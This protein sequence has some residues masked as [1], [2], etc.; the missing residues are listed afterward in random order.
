MFQHANHLLPGIDR[1]TRRTFNKGRPLISLLSSASPT[2]P[3]AEMLP[4]SLISPSNHWG[5]I[6]VLSFAASLAQL[7]GK[8]TLIGRLLG[9]P[10]TAMA[11]TFVLS[12]L[13]IVPSCLPD[14]SDWLTLLPS[15]GSTASAFL[16]ST[17]LTLAT[18][19]LLLGTSIRGKAL[20]RCGSLLG[21]FVVASMGTLLGAIIAILVTSSSYFLKNSSHGILGPLALPNGDGIKIASAL[22][23]KNIGGG[24]NYMAVCSC[25]NAAP[26]SIAAGLCVDNVMALAYFPLTSVLASKWDDVDDGDSK[27]ENESAHFS[28]VVI[29]DDEASTNIT[30][31]SLSHV[32]TIAAVLTAMGQLL[33]SNLHHIQHFLRIADTSSSINSLNLSLPITTLLAVLFSTYYPPDWFMSPTST[34]PSMTSK[35][36][37]QRNN[38]GRSNSIALAGE[39]LGT[40]LLYLF[41]ATAGAPGWRLKDS[42]QHSFPSIASF[43]II[44]YGVHLGVLW[45]FHRIVSSRNKRNGASSLTSFWDKI[46][47]PQRLLT[48]SSAAIGGPA[49]AAALAQSSQW[50]SLITPSLLVGNIGY[51]V[52]TFIA[53]LFY[54]GFR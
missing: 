23:A 33:N 46:A 24:I 41:F 27:D 50:K 52:A 30:V 18:P 35:D 4:S 13:S 53:L 48:A 20:R 14:C 38:I 11:L 47:A 36:R 43:L 1:I 25:L 2:S 45:G 49:T 37:L 8:K 34:H 22:L 42:I 26:E 5:N 17:S 44:L 29:V 9:A 21:S 6:A 51:A 32:F 3:V 19:L 7:L 31:E 39:R 10:V 40:S 12:S 28:D 16:Q 15:G 54:S